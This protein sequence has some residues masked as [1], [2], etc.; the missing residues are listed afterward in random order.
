MEYVPKLN[1]RTT[2][3]WITATSL[4]SALPHAPR[5]LADTPNSSPRVAHGYGTDPNLKAPL[6]TWPLI[7]APHQLQLTA[8]LADLILPGTAAAPAPSAIG[9]PDFVNEWVSAPYPDQVQDRETIFGGLA[10]IDAEA[11]RHG[12]QSFLKLDVQ[13]R[14]LIVGGIARKNPEDT[15]AAQSKFF[16]RLRYLVVGAYYTTPEGFKD[17]GYTGNVPIAAYPPITDE[18]RQIL[19]QALSSLGLSKDSKD[20]HA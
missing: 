7:M 5:A 3:Q 16:Q 8:V 20:P 12:Q 9:V 15:F 10:W 11:A 14:R 13:A 2:L 4:A 1:R 17:I 18:E 19:D 6:V